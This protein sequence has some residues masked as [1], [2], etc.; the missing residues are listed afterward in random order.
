MGDDLTV[1]RGIVPEGPLTNRRRSTKPCLADRPSWF[2]CLIVLWPIALRIQA[3]ESV[4]VLQSGDQP[5]HYLTWNGKPRL[6]IG[7]SVTQGWME[8]GENFDQRAY[9]DALAE[10]GINLLMLWA[11]KGTNAE[12]QRADARIGYDAPELWPWAGSPDDRSFDLRQFNP[13]YFTAAS[14]TGVI[15]GIERDRRVDHRS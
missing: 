5:G 15:R 11:F 14:R 7:D 12:L 10:R 4:T 9:V 1:R 2:L 8:S 13:A 3:S 6:L